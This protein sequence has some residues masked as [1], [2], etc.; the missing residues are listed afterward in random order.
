MLVF[1]VNPTI[2]HQKLSSSLSLL[3]LL[4]F[5]SLSLSPSAPNARYTHWKQT[6]FYLADCLTIKQGEQLSGTFSLSR[7]PKNMVSSQHTHK[8]THTHTSSLS[9]HPKAVT[10]NSILAYSLPVIFFLTR[11][12]S[13]S[14]YHM[15][16]RV[17]LWTTTC[18]RSII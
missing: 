11:G 3:M 12:T 4:L 5:L 10:F 16:L 13:I 6:V 9:Q 18:S 15:I 8:H 17:T 1:P 14:P 2:I 7:N